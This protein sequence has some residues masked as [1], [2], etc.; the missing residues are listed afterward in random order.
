MLLIVLLSIGYTFYRPVKVDSTILFPDT[1]ARVTRSDLLTH[2]GNLISTLQARESQD[3]SSL[4]SQ[5]D[6]LRQTRSIYVGIFGALLALALHNRDSNKSYIA[7]LCA[8]VLLYALDVHL[9]DLIDRTSDSKRITSN[10]LDSLVAQRPT[11]NIWYDMNYIQRNS[12]FEDV[13]D[14]RIARKIRSAFRPDIAQAVFYVLPFC[15]FY[16]VSTMRYRTKT[17]RRLTSRSS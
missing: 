9:L 5:G 12:Q 4:L 1:S 6:G 14:A 13:H 7:I 15:V 8:I 17:E 10:A 11:N 2:N 16:F 3:V